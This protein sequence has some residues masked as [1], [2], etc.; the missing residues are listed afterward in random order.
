MKEE[1]RR[2]MRVGFM[3]A[4]RGTKWRY[5]NPHTGV[6]AESGTASAQ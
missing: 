4:Y 3:A 5:V 1:T 2:K 6:T